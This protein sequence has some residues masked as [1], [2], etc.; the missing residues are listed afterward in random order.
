MVKIPADAY[1]I[2]TTAKKPSD[3]AR[4]LALTGGEDYEL[5]FAVP[6]ARL[7]ELERALPAQRWEYRRIGTLS[8]APAAHVMRGG[9]VM[10]FSHSGFDHFASRGQAE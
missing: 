7:T 3:S 5:C 1:K 9:N 6:P 10:E 2:V 8:A 4:L